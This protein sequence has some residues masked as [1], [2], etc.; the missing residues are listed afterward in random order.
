ME[1]RAEAVSQISAG[2]GI[3]LN[4]TDAMKDCCSKL[5]VLCASVTADTMIS[6]KQAD[7]G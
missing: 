3:L 7:E 1:G 4:L 2:K 5:A 6:P